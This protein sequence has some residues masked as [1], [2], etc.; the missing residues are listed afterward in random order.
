MVCLKIWYSQNLREMSH[1]MIHEICP[2]AR[3]T[4]RCP[5]YG[6]QKSKKKLSHGVY[7]PLE[8]I[9]STVNSGIFGASKWTCQ[10]GQ[11]L[12]PSSTGYCCESIPSHAC[13]RDMFHNMLVEHVVGNN[14]V[15]SILQHT[16]FQECWIY[17]HRPYRDIFGDDVFTNR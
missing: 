12:E 1:S 5:L 9:P 16:R 15:F 7:K 10:N 14:D 11:S 8:M 13:E 17:V 6:S 4:T 3:S 2:V